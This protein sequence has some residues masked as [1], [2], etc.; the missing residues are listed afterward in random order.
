MNAH[1]MDQET[2]ERLLVGSVVDPQDG[3][4]SLVRL[5][6]AVR[7][8]PHPAELRGEAAAMQAFHRARA[9]APLPVRALPARPGVL[10]GLAGLK[11][12]LAALAVAATGGVALAAV[13]G[14]LP[15]QPHRDDPGTRPSAAPATTPSATAD[16]GPSGVPATTDTPPSSPPASILGLCRAFQTEAG[17][18]PKQTLDNPVYRDLVVTAGGRNK[19]AG[20]CERAVK[21]AER[22]GAPTPDRGDAT[23]T[24]GS[25]G[26]PTHSTDVP[27]IP[28]IPATPPVPA[29]PS[30]PAGK[31]TLPAPDRTD[32]PRPD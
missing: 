7:A 2:V 27:T 1:R 32:P 18:K 8:A 5:L 11:L 4:A 25:S 31:P 30:I 19:V 28:P 10:A 6:A 14:T 20:Y 16:T 21:D 24:V 23:P 26:R 12:A 9:G 15:G 3:P 29:E 13:T 17:D 22:P